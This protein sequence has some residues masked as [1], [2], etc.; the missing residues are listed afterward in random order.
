MNFQALF[1]PRLAQLIDS[2]FFSERISSC[3]GWKQ[4][5]LTKTF[6]IRQDWPYYHS[7][8]VVAYPKA[9]PGFSRLSPGFRGP[10]VNSCPALQA[11]KFYLLGGWPDHF[12]SLSGSFVL[13]LFCFS[14]SISFHLPF[15]SLS[16]VSSDVP[17]SASTT[18]VRVLSRA[19]RQEKP[20]ELS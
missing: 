12:H 4:L 3:P 9:S 13:C 8:T 10:P 17:A 2:R 14:S 20:R 5:V 1:S 19:E 6:D 11:V 18:N 7:F 16:C 15:R